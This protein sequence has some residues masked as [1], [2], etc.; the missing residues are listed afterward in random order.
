MLII[1][2]HNDR[3]ENHNQNPENARILDTITKKSG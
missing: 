1:D 2:L 3:S